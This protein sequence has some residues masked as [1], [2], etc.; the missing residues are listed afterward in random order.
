M[1]ILLA[2]EI[3]CIVINIICIGIFIAL[4]INIVVNIILFIVKFDISVNR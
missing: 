3:Y 4:I 1:V 2:A